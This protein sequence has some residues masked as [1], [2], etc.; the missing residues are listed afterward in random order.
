MEIAI[1]SDSGYKGHDL[2]VT[3]AKL[4]KEILAK[5]RE[6]QVPITVAGM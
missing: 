2:K 1:P 3:K 6:T 5:S 4:N